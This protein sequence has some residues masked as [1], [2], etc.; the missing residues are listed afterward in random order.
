MRELK[1]IPLSFVVAAAL[2]ACAINVSPNRAA[3]LDV[4]TTPQEAREIATEAYIY[5][6]PLVSMDVTRR[7]MTNMEPGANAFAHLR[8]FPDAN[9]RAV[10]RPN[11]DTLYSVAWLDLTKGP[12]IVSAADTHGRYYLLPMLDMWSDVFAVPG[13]RTSGTKAANFAVVAPGWHGE[14]P[15]GVTRIQSSTPYV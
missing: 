7:Q 11:F 9:F 12:M 13:K 8:A 15:A 6:Y 5:F 4:S 2:A 3:A 14:L 1:Q 10:V